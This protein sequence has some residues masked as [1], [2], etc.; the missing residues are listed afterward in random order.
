MRL[1]DRTNCPARGASDDAGI[2]VR[3]AARPRWYHR[4]DRRTGTQRPARARRRL[5]FSSF[6]GGRLDFKSTF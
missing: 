2:R 6:L 4:R 5:H 3:A 1:Q